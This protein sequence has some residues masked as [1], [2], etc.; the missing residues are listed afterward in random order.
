MA[1]YMHF[2][3]FE[4]PDSPTLRE[5]NDRV[6]YLANDLRKTHCGNFIYGEI[7]YVISPAYQDKFFIS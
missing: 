1:N 2:Q 3:P 4:K 7:T 6:L 5:T